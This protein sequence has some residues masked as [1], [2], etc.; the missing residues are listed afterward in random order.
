M[1]NE[2]RKIN[3]D[4]CVFMNDGIVYLVDR[5]EVTYPCSTRAHYWCEPVYWAE[6]LFNESGEIL[7]DPIYILTT[8]VDDDELVSL[9]LPS[10]DTSF[11]LESEEVWDMAREEAH[12]TH[13]I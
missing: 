7:P 11:D 3:Y 8:D 9:E 5:S 10:E 12:S 13:R 6:E 1:L 2:P 4:F